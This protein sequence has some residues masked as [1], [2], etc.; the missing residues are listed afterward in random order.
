MTH[1]DVRSALRHSFFTAIAMA[2]DPHVRNW[3]VKGV[4]DQRMAASW[5][6]GSLISSRATIVSLFIKMALLG[7]PTQPLGALF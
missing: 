2:L 6:N 7:S 4:M 5:A 3:N 1:F